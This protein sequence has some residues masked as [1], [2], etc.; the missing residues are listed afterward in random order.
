LK[1]HET[2]SSVD[3]A[4]NIFNFD[5]RRVQRF[6]QDHQEGPIVGF[7]NDDAGSVELII[8]EHTLVTHPKAQTSDGRPMCFHLDEPEQLVYNPKEWAAFTAGVY[9]GEFDDDFRENS[10]SMIKDSKNPDGLIFIFTY[11][12]F[13]SFIDAIKSGKYDFPISQLE[14]L[15]GE[16][17]D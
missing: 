2:P 4:A 12:G 5:A 13:K 6:E 1:S 3:G 17:R 14:A 10:F 7:I 16:L 9:D 11:D 8:L 15:L